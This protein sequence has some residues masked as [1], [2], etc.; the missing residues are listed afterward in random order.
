MPRNP[1]T[2]A[3]FILSHGRPN[4]MPTVESLERSGYTGK[5]Y[6]LV[7]NEDKTVDEYR[8]RFGSENVIVFDKR[9]I[10]AETDS[11]DTGGNYGVVVYARNAAC[12][13][14]R[15]LGLE[16]HLQLD[17]DYTAFLH[18]YTRGDVIHSAQIRNMDAILDAMVKLLEDTGALTVAM[19]QGGDHIGGVYGS[20]NKG[21]LRKAMNSFVIRSDRPVKFRGRLN[22]DVNAYVVDG[23][24]GLLYLTAT[25]LQLNQVQT[26]SSTGGMSEAYLTSGTY[27]KSFYTVIMAPSC[28]TI[29]TMGRTDRRFHHS[30][31]WDNAVPKIISGRYRKSATV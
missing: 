24:R 15:E 28:V 30:I 25:A 21:L 8:S 20:I 13:I 31:R 1:E 18:R 4:N 26:Q 14:A 19:S 7:D 11:A 22:E 12:K 6:V 9:A 16:Y 27:L 2:F 5:T 10:A 23:S 17:D 29:G 3:I